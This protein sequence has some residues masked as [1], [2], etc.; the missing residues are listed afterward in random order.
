MSPIGDFWPESTRFARSV[1]SHNFLFIWIKGLHYLRYWH[2]NWPVTNMLFI[3]HVIS[4]S[5]DF[6]PNWGT[7]RAPDKMYT[8]KPL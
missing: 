3:V 6:D 2:I 1:N 7:N 5:K 8:V 4:Y